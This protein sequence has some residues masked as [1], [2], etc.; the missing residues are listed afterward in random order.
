MSTI[1]KLL[2]SLGLD[3]SDYHKG[4]TDS[5]K[6]T[7]GFGKSLLSI[8]TV[9]AGVGLAAGAAMVGIGVAA[10]KAFA[11][12][13]KG[14]AE[15]F[16]LMPT[17]SQATFDAMTQDVKNFSMEFGV[18][19]DQV[20]PGLYQAL[21]SGV[22][23]D[24]VFAFLEV[25]QKAATA[26]VT[27][28]TTTVN[29]ITSV[30]NAY[31]S[32]VITAAQASDQMF[33]AV[34]FGKTTFEELSASLYNVNPIAASLGVSFGDVTSAIAAMTAQ[35][36]PTAQTTTQLRSMMV[37]LGDST[38]QVGKHFE[39]LTGVGFKEFIA[40]G[41]N[42]QQALQLLEGSAVKSGVGINELFSSVEAGGAA[43]ALTGKGTQLFNNALLATAQSAGSTDR[44]FNTMNQ[45]LEASFGKIQAAGQVFLITIGE[46]LAPAIALVTNALVGLM[47]SK[48]AADFIQN[49]GNG[50]AE[51]VTVL[52]VFGTRLV[53]YAKLAYAWGTNIT[54]QLAS[55]IASA[56]SIIVGVM[57]QIGAVIAS[58]LAPGSP[59]K[60]TP[61][62]DKWGMEAATLYFDSWGKGDTSA[63][64]SLASTL[65]TTLNALV[66]TGKFSKEGVIPTMLAGRA[67]L[68]KVFSE[69][70]TLGEVSQKTFDDVVASMG[71]A[72]T[73]I[74][75]LIRAYSNLS[76]ATRAVDAA[77]TELNDT[78][79]KYSQMLMP[80][81]A[82]MKALQDREKEI[83][84]M[85]RIE[86]LNATIA[87]GATSAADRELAQNEIAQINLQKQIKGVNEEKDAVT[88][89]AQAKLDA[90]K[91][92][93]QAAQANVETQQQAIDNQNETNQLIGQQIALL[94]QIASK[95][96][97]MGGGGGGG[98]GGLG[99]IGAM[100]PMIPEIKI[101]T[102]DTAPLTALA[103]K[104]DE[105][106]A[107]AELFVDTIQ[108]KFTAFGAGLNAVAA[109]F[110]ALGTT[111]STGF[112][113]LVGLVLPVLDR[114]WAGITL[115]VSNIA[116]QWANLIETFNKITPVFNVIAQVVGT[117]VLAIVGFIAGALPGAML[118]VGGVVQAVLGIINV[119]A[120]LTMGFVNVIVALFN[121]DLPAA[122]QAI[123]T[124]FAN[125]GAQIPQIL[126]GLLQVVWGIIGGLVAGVIGFFKTLYDVIIGHSIIP[127]LVAGIIR[128][129]ATLPE[130]V[131]GFIQTMV[132]N[133]LARFMQLK[134]DA[135]KFIGEMVTNITGA[136]T[137]FASTVV[138]SAM[139]VG[140]AI[141]DGIKQGITNAWDSLKS[142]FVDKI[143]SLLPAGMAG[144]LAKSPSRL[145][146]DKMGNTAIMGGILM[147]MQAGLP[148]LLAFIGNAGRKILSEFL[149]TSAAFTRSAG[150]DV[151]KSL[152]DIE[153]LD[154]FQPLVDASEALK[155][156][157]D[158][159]L[160]VSGKLLDINAEI[161][162]L[163]S[164]P[165]SEIGDH[166]AYNEELTKLYAEQAILLNE[167]ANSQANLANLGRTKAEA[168]AQSVAQQQKINQI[169]EEARKQYDTAQQQA[170]TM[171]NTDA[172]SALDFFNKRKAQIEEMAQLEKQRALATTDQQRADLDTQIA[173]TRAA[174]S[175]EQTQ[176]AVDIYISGQDQRAMGNEDIIKIIEDALRRAG[177]TVDIR[178]R[179]A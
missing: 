41:G 175:A 106:R 65:Q 26:G 132:T 53:A 107:K 152:L 88:A 133:V 39:K 1:A 147:G 148:K 144:I 32:E 117:V 124:M 130:A 127:E 167:Q 85:Q 174:Q 122:G 146:A 156:A 10:T 126:G 158:Q 56:I 151:F 81:N 48:G 47:Q 27:D 23:A 9:A 60:I 178:A 70:A 19:P 35:G 76:R 16:T 78:T 89:T 46:K 162:A 24:N 153:H 168:Q 160:G 14:M 69:L 73:Q 108:A 164:T 36:V 3:S 50:L 172:Q 77:Q 5:A 37:E 13:E 66:D 80:L 161:V 141:I 143:K 111:V 62:L 63:F 105:T 61:D 34:V 104:V 94:D 83:Q 125:I 140:K 84:D 54:A 40:N 7:D 113:T 68:G 33:A 95:A 51:V 15:V 166:V 21:S 67:G 154:P 6:A 170:L 29:G 43:L 98:L 112:N 12:F 49:F 8:G 100:K 4:L 171:M 87:D 163:A 137:T 118:A 30:I 28:L 11:G 91:I 173:L 82:E 86:E 123:I 119:A 142:W 52:I 109:P 150:I 129:I 25:A 99:G 134:D 115:G 55:G 75:S 22:P 102:I 103:A 97:G 90:A 64:K 139:S 135:F 101:P 136:I 31:G 128:F 17:A 155:T 110:I 131:L 79:A 177:I 149:G 72:G 42:V 58:W 121:G 57:Q 2:V 179:T 38:T 45:T 44:A 169:A 93:Q 157:Q 59:P 116:P 20:I 71:P 92:E 176:Q 138:S 165:L 74:G 114:L 159:A 96:A 145:F 18:L 120:D